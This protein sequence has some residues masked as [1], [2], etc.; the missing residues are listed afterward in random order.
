MGSMAEDNTPQN[1]YPTPPSLNTFQ[2]TISTYLVCFNDTAVR[3]GSLHELL[4]SETRLWPDQCRRIRDFL[5]DILESLH[6]LYTLLEDPAQLPQ[7]PLPRNYPFLMVLQNTEVLIKKLLSIIT[8]QSACSYQ[9]SIDN[10]Q[11]KQNEP[12][13]TFEKFA[14]NYAM[15][16]IH[17]QSLLKQLAIQ[18][19]LYEQ[20]SPDTMR[21]FLLK[22]ANNDERDGL[23]ASEAG[24]KKEALDNFVR[25]LTLIQRV[26]EPCREASILNN[27]G[28]TYS[29]L[30]YK[31]EAR[32]YLEKALAFV[33]TQIDHTKEI[34]IL[35]NLGLVYADIGDHDKARD[36]LQ[37]VLYFCQQVKNPYMEASAYNSLGIVYNYSGQRQE[38]LRYYDQ[39]L[40]IRQR[41]KD[42]KGQGATLI[43]I[44]WIYDDRGQKE[45]ARQ[46]YEEALTISRKEKD[47]WSEAKTLTNLGQLC[48]D[49]EQYDPAIMYCKQALTILTEEV[50]DRWGK[51]KVLNNLVRIYSKLGKKELAKRCYDHALENSREVKDRRGEGRILSNSYL[52][53][54][55]HS[56]SDDVNELLDQALSL[57]RAVGDKKGEGWVLNNLGRFYFELGK[58]DDARE[59][60][61]MAL[62]IRIR[63]GDR[64]GLGWTLF[65]IG[66][67]SLEEINYKK[68]LTCLLSA[69]RILK[70]VHSLDYTQ[71]QKSIDTVQKR[72]N[73]DQFEEL[74]QQ[75]APDVDHILEA[76]P[77][78]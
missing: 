2:T 23:I 67:L 69:Q 61:E 72:I 52:I 57:C 22:R 73:K 55:I 42:L 19:H 43:N 3:L 1:S 20:I 68:A 8:N 62:Q 46:C 30:G 39:A 29:A 75:I 26:G 15:V 10:G 70:D 56:Q 45:R 24:H 76:D 44:G 78:L 6:Q 36:C 27:L 34:L 17:T 35:N 33:K 9:P 53:H 49:L 74:V 7:V 32:D 51:S 64:R 77:V 59:N 28:R 21:S 5:N 54:D 14:T 38:A 48:A 40:H 58:Q 65:N 60:F 18:P 66:M 12:L 25:A 16:R 41:I 13:R 4:A 31:E 47:L 37:Q 63:I 71:V 11:K 50:G